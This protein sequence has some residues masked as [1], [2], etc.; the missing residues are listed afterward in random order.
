MRFYGNERLALFM[1]HKRKD[2]KGILEDGILQVLTKEQKVMHDHNTVNYNHRFC[3]QNLECT[4][5]IERDLKKNAD[6][7]GHTILNEIIDLISTTIKDRNDLISSGAKGFEQ[8]YIDKFNSQMT[9]M[10]EEAKALAESNT[11]KYSGDKE[12]AIV[13]RIID[14][15]ENIPAWLYDF[16]LPTTNNLSERALRG[17]KTKMKVSG[18][19]ASVETANYGAWLRSYMETCRR[20]GINEIRAFCRLCTGNPFTVDEILSYKP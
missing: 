16:S 15:R 4:A 12:R 9:L 5:H 11:S 3:F 14:Y 6:E 20:N 10:L 18:Q 7:T 17:V 19:Y 8:S 2:L 13:N 1:A